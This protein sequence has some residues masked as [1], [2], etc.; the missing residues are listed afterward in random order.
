MSKQKV[1]LLGATGE[2]GT[3]ILNSLLTLNKF[4][5]TALVR[6]SSAEKPDVQAL[7]EKGVKILIADISGPAEELINAL[8]GIDVVIS[9][10]GGMAQMAQMG[11]VEAAKKAGVKRFVP[12]DFASVCP[13]GV[14]M[15][16]DEKEE[17][18]T[19][20]K[21]LGLGYTFID[22][23]YWYQLSFPPLPSGRTSYAMFPGMQV[24]LH[25]DGEAK[26]ILIDIR[27][28]GHF[29]AR[30]IDDERTLNKYVYGWG[31]ILTENQIYDMMEEVSG[32]KLER[33]YVPDEEVV[34]QEK[35]LLQ[36]FENDKTNVRLRI[37]VMSTQYAISKY[38]RRDNTPE[39]A[40]SLG[41]L[42]ARELYPDLKPKS[43]KEFVGDLV[44]GKVQRPYA[45]GMSM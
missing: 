19:Q 32:E 26:N 39:N 43:F 38:V 7:T 5:I 10:I 13:V 16:R 42:D 34:A 27:D 30:I 8:T 3:S 31:D 15:L 1:L 11:L 41:Y 18:H 9:A 23:G 28:I 33:V 6:P 4:E 24:P 45:K 40:K 35:Q 14:M 22:V 29:V 20:I 21:K 36:A 37:G 25:G 2:T 12:C 44:D 17:I